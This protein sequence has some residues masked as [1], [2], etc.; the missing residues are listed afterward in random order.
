MLQAKLM[1]E[2]AGGCNVTARLQSLRGSDRKSKE[3]NKRG[4]NAWCCA[5]KPLPIGFK[6]LAL[7]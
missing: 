2:F 1:K 6:I 3:R 5:C 4:I 7:S